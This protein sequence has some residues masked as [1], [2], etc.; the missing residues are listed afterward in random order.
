MKRSFSQALVWAWIFLIWNTFCGTLIGLCL[1]RPPNGCRLSWQEGIY[2]AGDAAIPGMALYLLAS[3]CAALL[4]V[5]LTWDLMHRWYLR[6]QQ[7]DQR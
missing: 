5:A 6:L 3:F 4:A 7:D 1:W 2:C